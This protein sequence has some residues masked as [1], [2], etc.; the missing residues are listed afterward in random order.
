MTKLNISKQFPSEM[1]RKVIEKNVQVAL[2][3][4]IGDGDVTANLISN[5]HYAHATVIAREEAVLSGSP[6]FQKVF[7][8]LDQKIKV[9][10]HCQDGDDI[11]GNDIV[12]EVLGPAQAILT[13]ERT[14]LNFLQTLSGTATKTRGFV[15]AL[16]CSNTKILDTRKTLPGLRLAQKYAVLCGGGSNHR[17]GLYDAILIKENHIL[18][19]GSILEA[20]LKARHCNP[21]MRV[22]V[23]VE[24]IEELQQAIDAQA[25]MVLLDN[26]S[27]EDVKK[28]IAIV[29]NS[30]LV[31]LSGGIDLDKVIK[32]KDLGADFIS[33][34]ALTKDLH[35]TDF[36][37][38]IRS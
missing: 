9:K 22:E 16:G 38:T 36:S 21:S 27:L 12:C 24:N 17:I 19:C 29:N 5:Q 28:A 18:A 23:E 10:W 13:G 37:M 34:G 11:Q 6:W 7:E 35:A 20:V 3:E 15:N 2:E 1:L 25:N 4:D 8:M 32:L 31:E 26:F 14:A 30:L 33:I